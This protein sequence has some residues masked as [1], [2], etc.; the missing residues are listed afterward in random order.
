MPFVLYKARL[1]TISENKMYQE[2]RLIEEIRKELLPGEKILCKI[3]A[4][5]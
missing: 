4:T 2:G 5:A 1:V 3:A